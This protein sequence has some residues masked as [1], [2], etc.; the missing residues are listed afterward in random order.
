MSSIAGIAQLGERQTEDLKVACSIHA[1]RIFFS[2]TLSLFLFF[3]HPPFI[4]RSQLKF[5]V[6]LFLFKPLNTKTSFQIPQLK[7][8]ACPSLN[9]ESKG[10]LEICYE[11]TRSC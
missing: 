1:H 3:V 10:K 6:R 9:F 11:F 4:S 7:A 8:L 5:L 2:L